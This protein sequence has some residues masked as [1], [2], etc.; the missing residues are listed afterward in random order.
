M[1]KRIRGHPGE[2]VITPE[3]RFEALDLPAK[4]LSRGDIAELGRTMR[5][6]TIAG[7][8]GWDYADAEQNHVWLT[9]ENVVKYPRREGPLATNCAAVWPDLPKTTLHER[10]ALYLIEP[11]VDA[12]PVAVPQL[13][14]GV[15]DTLVVSRIPGTVLGFQ[16]IH[17]FNEKEQIDLG[18]DI[19]QFVAWMGKSVSLEVYEDEIKKDQK[20]FNREE[21]LWG[22]SNKA[23]IMDMY[24]QYTLAVACKRLSQEYRRY[25]ASEVLKPTI[26]GHEDLWLPNLVFDVSDP[27]RRKLH[28]VIDYGNMQPSTPER[29]FRWLVQI[30]RPAVKAAIKEY[31]NLTGSSVSEHLVW[32]WAR[33]QATLAGANNARNG[34]PR[35]DRLIWRRVLERVW[36]NFEWGEI[37]GDYTYIHDAEG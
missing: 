8:T 15:D 28:G 29:E 19:A 26:I 3:E 10:S 14:H 17:S 5:L 32:F 7:D 27:D 9:E 16:D 20:P 4:G 6:L 13:V 2:K 25:R 12:A 34:F 18:I 23:R 31:Q 30:G 35:N 21:H 1:D 37:T 24:D 11:Y 36:P 22:L 33:A